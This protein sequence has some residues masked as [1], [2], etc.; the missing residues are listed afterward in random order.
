[1]SLLDALYQAGAQ[2]KA[3]FAITHPVLLP[4]AIQTIRAEER[5]ESVVVTN[6]L[7]VPSEKRIDK[8]TVLSIAPLLSDIIS[9]IYHG[10]SITDRLTVS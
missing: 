2:G 9:R 5:I 4:S 7:P 1:L 10:R 3:C 8:I 6:S